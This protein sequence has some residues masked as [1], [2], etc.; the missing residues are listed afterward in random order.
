MI[1][2]HEHRRSSDCTCTMSALEPD[3]NCPVHT[4][5]E[6]PPRCEVCGQYM[7][8]PNYYNGEIAGIS[9]SS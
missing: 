7:S 5:G 8:W 2:H 4:G 3:D 1:A 9:E 6:W